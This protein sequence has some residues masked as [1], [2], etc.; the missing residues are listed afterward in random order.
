MIEPQEAGCCL[1]GRVWALRGGLPI[2]CCFRWPAN[3]EG[4]IA[5]I[6][7]GGGPRRGISLRLEPAEKKKLGGRP[8]IS[9]S[10]PRPQPQ[11]KSKTPQS[12]AAPISLPP[13]SPSPRP[14]VSITLSVF[15]NV[16]ILHIRRCKSPRRAPIPPPLLH[17]RCPHIG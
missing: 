4:L 13:F 8:S 1:A 17:F 14:T 11:F 9:Q 5:G 12:T 16:S 3:D 7:R 15:S 2:G 10:A 6:T